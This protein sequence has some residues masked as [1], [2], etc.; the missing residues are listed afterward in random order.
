MD[1]YCSNSGGKRSVAQYYS[2]LEKCSDMEFI[3]GV[4]HAQNHFKACRPVPGQHKT[5]V[6]DSFP[7]YLSSVPPSQQFNNV[8]LSMW[9]R[10]HSKDEANVTG[11]AL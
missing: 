5:H 8:S 6:F 1:S 10:K 4:S 11:A 7:P 3:G 9:E 2:E